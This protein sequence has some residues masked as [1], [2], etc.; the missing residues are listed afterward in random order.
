MRKRL[1]L[2]VDGWLGQ[3]EAANHLGVFSR[4][5]QRGRRAGVRADEVH[6]PAAELTD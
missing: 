1:T 2:T 3:H 4:R 6:A 5:H